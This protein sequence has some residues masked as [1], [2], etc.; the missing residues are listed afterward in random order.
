MVFNGAIVE[1]HAFRNEAGS[2]PKRML[3]LLRMMPQ[4]KTRS[5][6]H[7][8]AKHSGNRAVLSDLKK[9]FPIISSSDRCSNSEVERWLLIKPKGKGCCKPDLRHMDLQLPELPSHHGWLGNP[10]NWSL[11]VLKLL[12]LETTAVNCSLAIL[13]IHVSRLIWLWLSYSED[14]WWILVNAIEF[15]T[16]T[17]YLF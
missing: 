11:Q 6:W 1:F 8:G 5:T 16:V 15:L 9:A 4:N 17:F 13:V 10:G 14:L 2:N 12:M 7:L 3:W